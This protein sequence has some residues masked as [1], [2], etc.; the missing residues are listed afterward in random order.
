[1]TEKEEKIFVEQA[2]NN[3][4]KAFENLI[5]LHQ[6]KLFC[7]ALN[8]TGGN[9]DLAN[10]LLQEAFIK[11]F[12][13]IKSYK[14]KSSFSSWLWRIVSNEF[15]NY[16]KNLKIKLDLSFEDLP[17]YE[18]GEFPSAEAEYELE[19]KNLELRKL[20]AMLPF[21]YNE[22]ISLVDFQ[23]LNYE[24]AAELAGIKV[25]AMKSRI[26]KARLI[27]AELV[28]KYEKLLT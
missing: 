9:V 12:V 16:N 20:V 7:F 2:Q 27:L 14:K 21:I 1:M 13:Y 6:D 26:Y 10:D 28:L 22:A 18:P 3:D 25:P 17:G 24:E 8:I 19:E 5:K 4:K 11:A 23:G 15:H